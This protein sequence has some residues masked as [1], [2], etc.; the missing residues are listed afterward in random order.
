[1]NVETQNFNF[2]NLGCGFCFDSRWTNV[3]FYST[4]PSVIACNLLKKI[5]FSDESFEVVYHSHLL[6]HIPKEDAL[7]FMQECFRVLKS[8]GII[9]VVVPDLEAI[10]NNYIYWREIAIKGDKDAHKNYE[11]TMIEMFDQVVRN[12]SGGEMS[13]YLENLDIP[14]KEF[15]RQR[16][17][18]DVEQFWNGSI[19]KKNV[20]F[21]VIQKVRAFLFNIRQFIVYGILWL[22]G[23]DRFVESFKIGFFRTSGEV[24][25]WMYDDFS[26]KCLLEEAGFQDIRVLSAYESQI[27]NYSIFALDVKD[28]AIRKADSLFVE[29]TKK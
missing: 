27:P 15:V 22:V 4:G 16:L 12:K 25:R 28:G 24:H 11:W 17:G 10:I 14:N 3:D 9:R 18:Q 7:R 19:K 13:K 2:L 26:V 6:E 29:A 23:G 5:P 21:S 20:K 8:G 1:M